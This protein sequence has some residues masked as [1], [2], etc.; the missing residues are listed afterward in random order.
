MKQKLTTL[1]AVWL[2]DLDNHLSNPVGVRHIEKGWEKARISGLLDGQT[3]LPPE[4][5]FT[6]IEL[7]LEIAGLE[8][9]ELNLC[10][11]YT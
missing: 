3:D 6:E 9:Q 2:V 11:W 7:A 4:D 5:P 8:A 10:Q 1:H